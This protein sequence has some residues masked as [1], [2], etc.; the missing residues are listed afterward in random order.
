[1]CIWRG[2]WRRF[3]LRVVWVTLQK[4][5]KSYILYHEMNFLLG[6]SVECC[7]VFLEQNSV[8]DGEEIDNRQ[9]NL[10]SSLGNIFLFVREESKIHVARRYNIA[11]PQ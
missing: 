5:W 7:V 9:P 1:M 10:L 6:C 2:D 8:E 11:V 4:W 3:L